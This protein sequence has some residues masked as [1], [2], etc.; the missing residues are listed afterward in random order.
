M[1]LGLAVTELFGLVAAIFGAV[2]LIL[3]EIETRTIYLILTR[4]FDRSTYVLGRFLGLVLS[5]LVSMSL[6]GLLHFSVLMAKG[7]TPD[8]KFFLCFPMMF[9]KVMMVTAL[10][11]FFSLFSSSSVVSIVFTVFFWML[12]HF[13]PE[14]KFMAARSQNLL[15]ISG[16]KALLFLIPN[17]QFVNYRDVFHQ[18]GFVQM[19][20]LYGMVYALIYTS[21]C[22]A[23]SIAIFSKK[24]L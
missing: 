2:S 10:A 17:F 5:V 19:Q 3:E 11:L 9:L 23:L 18:P 22:L 1:N 6:M 14:L 21:A 8:L 7:W 16:I 15:S 12:G 24:E 13:G 4:P 20:N